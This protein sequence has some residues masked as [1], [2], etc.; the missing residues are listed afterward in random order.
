MT[1][2]F[3]RKLNSKV[4]KIIIQSRWPPPSLY[5]NLFKLLLQNI[6]ITITYNDDT[7]VGSLIKISICQ[8]WPVRKFRCTISDLAHILHTLTIHQGRSLSFVRSF[9]SQTWELPACY[10]YQHLQPSSNGLIITS[11]E[12]SSTAAVCYLDRNS[13]LYEYFICISWILIKLVFPPRVWKMFVKVYLVTPVAAAGLFSLLIV[14]ILWFVLPL[15]LPIAVRYPLGTTNWTLYKV[16][17]N[18]DFPMRFT[19]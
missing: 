6:N 19:P 10:L 17:V 1:H 9:T 11:S 4:L 7:Q 8:S 2:I 14:H 5:I 3:F 12:G 13:I 16:E 18:N 15:S